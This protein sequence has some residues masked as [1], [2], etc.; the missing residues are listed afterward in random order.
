MAN[1]MNIEKFILFSQFRSKYDKQILNDTDQGFKYIFRFYIRL[2]A[3]KNDTY[4]TIGNFYQINFILSDTN[5]LK[6]HNAKFSK[7]LI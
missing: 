5:T 1:A 2:H 3:E 6:S 7:Q 4:A